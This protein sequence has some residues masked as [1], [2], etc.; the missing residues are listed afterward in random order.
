MR[1]T[2]RSPLA[3]LALTLALLLAPLAAQPALAQDAAPS[4]ASPAASAST[5]SASTTSAEAPRPSFMGQL[6]AQAQRP[7]YTQLLTSVISSVGF[8]PELLW[9]AGLQLRLDHA[10]SG[11]PLRVGGFLQSEVL[12]D[13]AVRIAGGLSGGAWFMGCQLGLAYRFQSD[14]YWGTLGVQIGKSIDFGI[15][16][17]GGRVVI[18]IAEFSFTDAQTGP[19]LTSTGIEGAVYV[20]VGLPTLLEGERP[21]CGCPH[22]D[23]HGTE[24]E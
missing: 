23:H 19:S 24:R 22:R 3:T 7:G 14:R 20:S 21:R 9:G 2:S 15:F 16:Q 11:L 1:S 13:G 8:G 18:P 4:D 17:L 6:R 10:P 12:T 5:A